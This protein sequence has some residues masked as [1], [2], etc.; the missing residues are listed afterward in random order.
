VDVAADRDAMNEATFL[1]PKGRTVTFRYRPD[2]NDWN[3]LWACLNEDEY[4]LRSLP[5]IR[6]AV[7]V[8]GYL[9]G[10][11]IGL[12][13]DHPHARVLIIEPVPDNVALIDWAIDANRVRERV[14]VVAGAV[15][16]GRKVEVAYGY[17]GTPA[18]EH[19]AWVGNSTLAYDAP[20]GALEHDTVSYRS[21]TVRDVVKRIA[22]DIL[23]IDTEGAEW[24]FLA[25]DA[26][27]LP[28]I[29]GEWHPVRQHTQAEFA[30]LLAATHDVTFSGPEN[31][32]GG[33]VAVAR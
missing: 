20:G 11:G 14:E 26:A 4:G 22:P 32:P 30:A 5:T 25:H 3:T 18:L 33:F 23:K 9:G 21:L 15:G 6:T 16:D 31:G 27:L 24:A 1:T 10:I 7:D 13:L 19:H 28:R 12:A 8:G 17:R 2:T 29:V